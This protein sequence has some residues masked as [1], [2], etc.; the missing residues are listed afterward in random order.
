MKV[1]I[2]RGL[3]SAKLLDKSRCMAHIAHIYHYQHKRMHTLMIALHQLNCVEEAEENIHEVNYSI[4]VI[5]MSF[6]PLI[7]CR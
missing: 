1:Y 2:D 5:Y 7:L 6:T 4:F 3:D